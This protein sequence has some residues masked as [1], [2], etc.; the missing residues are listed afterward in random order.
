MEMMGYN[1][2]RAYARM[3]RLLAHSKP[4]SEMNRVSKTFG[5][6]GGCR[7]PDHGCC[8]VAEKKVVT[9]VGGYDGHPICLINPLIFAKYGYVF[10]SSGAGPIN[11]SM[12]AGA[13][14]GSFL[15]APLNGVLVADFNDEF[16]FDADTRS[17]TLIVIANLP[18]AYA[19]GNGF[20]VITSLP[21][22]TASPVYKLRRATPFADECFKVRVGSAV[23]VTLG[24]SA[25]IYTI[26]TFVKPCCGSPITFTLA[27]TNYGDYSVG[28]QVSPACN[29]CTKLV[30]ASPKC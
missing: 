13:E 7:E 6:C 28:V 1:A 18:L 23:F 4:L 5:Y 29:P 21:S 11:F 12:T 16:G 9:C 22:D 27:E 14:P 24:D 19:G 20:Y 15:L 25:G 30:C 10:G 3:E 26:D 17:G 2:K 8:C